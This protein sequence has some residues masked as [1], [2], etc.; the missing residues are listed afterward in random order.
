MIDLIHIEEDN[1]GLRNL[2]PLSA[3]AHVLGDMRAAVAADERNRDP[4]GFGWSDIHIITP[5]SISYLDMGLRLAEAAAVL[6]PIMP[7]VKRFYATGPAGFE[8]GERD[9]F[10][11]YD[12]DAWCFGRGPR[13]YMKLD[14]EGDCVK[15]IWFDLRGNDSGDVIALRRS[16]EAIDRLVPS[17]VADYLEEEIGRAGDAGFLDR[18]FSTP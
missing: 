3:E 18:Y 10:G 9:P 13:C 4:A 5:P 15:T 7:R 1:W 17:L 6:E 12:D 8:P 16:I 2:Y 14:I 11:S